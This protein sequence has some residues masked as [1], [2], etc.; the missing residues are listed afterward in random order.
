MP[1]SAAYWRAR[2]RSRPATVVTTPPPAAATAGR[3]A[4]RAM[5]AVPMI[6]QR[7]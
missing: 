5:R 1:F 2:S 4:V 7:T 3:N 6:P